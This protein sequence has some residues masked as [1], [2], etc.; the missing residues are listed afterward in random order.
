MPLSLFVLGVVWD[1]VQWMMGAWMDGWTVG[2]RG[3]EESHPQ[4]TPTQHHPTQ[5]THHIDHL[6]S[7]LPSSLPTSCSS[8]CARSALAPPPPPPPAAPAPPPSTAPPAGDGGSPTGS[9]RTRRESLPRLALPIVLFGS[10]VDWARAN[11]GPVCCMCVVYG[12]TLDG[13][14]MDVGMED[15][16][17]VGWKNTTRLG[18]TSAPQIKQSL[19]RP[20]PASTNSVNHGLARSMPISINPKPNVRRLRQIR[21]QSIQHFLGY[22]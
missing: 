8:T 3:S 17:L 6:I 14:W 5:T 21:V 19:N 12:W 9:C 15:T 18:S 1:G 4:P 2:W 7:L 10:P 20:I 13:R 11:G 22:R 16:A